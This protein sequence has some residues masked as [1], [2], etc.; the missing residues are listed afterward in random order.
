MRAARSLAIASLTLLHAACR[1]EARLPDVACADTRMHANWSRDSAFALCVPS[2]FA[3]VGDGHRWARRASSSS[4]GDWLSVRIVDSAA[5]ASDADAR[6]RPSF[7]DAPG[8]AVKDGFEVDSLVVHRDIILGVE[9]F[10][11]TALV[12]GGFAGEVRAPALLAWWRVAPGRWAIAQARATRPAT[13]DTL[14]RILLEL[15]V[16]ADHRAPDSHRGA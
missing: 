13:L 4:T 12:T 5:V 2:D 9:A 1:A 8:R 16:R 6:W 10:V 7:R 3:V 14:R 15:H 11:E